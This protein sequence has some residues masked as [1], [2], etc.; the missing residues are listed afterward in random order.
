MEIVLLQPDFETQQGPLEFEPPPYALIELSSYLT[1]LNIENAIFDASFYSV[2]KFEKYL[3][4]EK[5]L[6][7]GVNL[8]ASASNNVLEFL[9]D[10][11]KGREFQLVAFGPYC[12][13]REEMLLMLGFDF[14]ISGEVEDTFLELFS[15]LK[16]PMNPFFD[17]VDGISY[18]NAAGE[19]TSTPERV[20][21][22]TVNDYP[23]NRLETL[24][25][26]RYD[27][28]FFPYST[29]HINYLLI[30]EDCQKSCTE[31]TQELDYLKDTVNGVYLYDLDV[32]STYA[33]LL[34]QTFEKLD[35]HMN[36]MV[37]VKNLE[38]LAIV[39]QAGIKNICIDWNIVR[40]DKKG[41]FSAFENIYFM[42]DEEFELAE[43][44]FFI[45]K[46]K[47]KNVFT[48]EVPYADQV[49]IMKLL[50]KKTVKGNTIFD[51]LMRL[52]G[53]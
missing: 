46:Y 41:H 6:V 40:I 53:L 30:S 39:Q 5:P 29:K 32:S 24:E 31:V 51:K 2:K 33:L 49:K 25:L 36:V 9:G 47:V 3:L 23:W 7:V 52:L 14:V 4:K 20:I 16:V 50:K 21:N 19:M 37:L 28:D 18:K 35:L 10:N 13:G 27:T 43:L 17:H 26:E 8:H 22:K 45:N 42:V 12:K 34:F 38:E 11:A 48:S 44:K 15:T 1:K